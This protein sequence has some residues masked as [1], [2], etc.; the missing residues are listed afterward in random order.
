MHHLVIAFFQ[1]AID[2]DVLDIKLCEMLK[3]III[4]PGFDHFNTL[5]ILFCGYM[6]DFDL[7]VCV[8][9]CERHII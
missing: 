2:V 3:D 1:L 5:F 8:K 4:E 7:Q 6:L 9:D